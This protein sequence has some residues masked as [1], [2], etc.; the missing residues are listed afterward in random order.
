MTDSLISELERTGTDPDVLPHAMRYFVSA[1]AA[2]AP[3]RRMRDELLAAGIDVD[4]VDEA[5]DLLQRDPALLEAAAL[6]VLQ[7]GWEDPVDR[8][9]ARNALG[10]AGTKLPV[11]EAAL[12]SIVAVYG[13]WLAATKGRRTRERVIRRD[14]DGGW[15]ESEKTEWYGPSG[16]L[17]AIG[18]V[19][20]LRPRLGSEDPSGGLPEGDQPRSLPPDNGD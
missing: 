5:V 3:P 13:M 6:A 2:D 7:A 11:V 10:G 17:E 4:R 12:I 9:L 18:E 8:D 14:A 1:I 20:G 15:V 16:P 19:L